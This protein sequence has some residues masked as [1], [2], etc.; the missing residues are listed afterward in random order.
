MVFG[1]GRIAV[2]HLVEDADRGHDPAVDP[3]MR[4]DLAPDDRP[5]TCRPTTASPV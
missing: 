2:R 3:R 4:A 1:S 5:T